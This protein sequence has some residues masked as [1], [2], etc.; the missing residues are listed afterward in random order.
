MFKGTA[1]QNMEIMITQKLQNLFPSRKNDIKLGRNFFLV[2]IKSNPQY[3][4]AN[5]HD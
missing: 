5:K 4:A 3:D 1:F 2:K